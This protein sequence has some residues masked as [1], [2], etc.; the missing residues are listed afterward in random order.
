[1]KIINPTGGKLRSD[2][3][4][5]G[6]YGAN[7][8]SRKHKGKDYE[9]LAGQYVFAP[10]AGK[11]ERYAR[12]YKNDDVFSGIV[13]QGK[14]AWA[15]MFYM[16]PTVEQGEEVYAGQIIGFAQDISAKHGAD[17]TIH[18][19]LEIMVKLHDGKVVSINPELFEEETLGSGVGSG[20]DKKK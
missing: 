7:R 5:H 3:Q 8:G 17:M 2:S 19:H 9:A 15:K 18:V 6:A 4:G 13:I 20:G 11:I 10:I 1:M 14:N 12:P 16:Q